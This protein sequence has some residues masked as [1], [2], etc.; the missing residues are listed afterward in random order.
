[1]WERKKKQREMNLT[2]LLVA[3]GEDD[4]AGVVAD[5]A[6]GDAHVAG[7]AALRLPVEDEGLGAEDPELEVVAVGARPQLLHLVERHRCPA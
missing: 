1:M 2:T 4:D 5:D 6:L 3:G 7:P